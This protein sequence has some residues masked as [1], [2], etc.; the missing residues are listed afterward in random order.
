M[1]YIT[2]VMKGLRAIQVLE[3]VMCLRLHLAGDSRSMA[4]LTRGLF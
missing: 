2:K 3:E 4:V 1:I